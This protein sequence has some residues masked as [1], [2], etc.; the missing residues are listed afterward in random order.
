MAPDRRPDCCRAEAKG[1]RESLWEGIMGSLAHLARIGKA[2]T[3]KRFIALFAFLITLTPDPSQAAACD[4][5][6]RKTIRVTGI[7]VPSGQ[8]YSRPFVFAM[9]L[10]CH[11]TKVPVT[12]Q[13]PTGTL[14]V[15][16]AR[17]EVEV[18]GTLIWNRTLVDGHYEINDPSSVTCVSVA[19]AEPSAPERHEAAAPSTQTAPPAATELPRTQPRAVGSGVWVGRYTDNRG[20]GDVTF[21]L[22]RGESMMSGTWKQRTGGGG[23]VTGTVEPGGRRVLLKMENIAPE[24]PGTFEGSAEMTETTLVATYHGKDCAGDVTGGRLELRPQ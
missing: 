6:V 1:R 21:M 5:W 17:Q 8:A 20:T 10:D 14:P 13:R 12:V 24:C 22:M 2:G 9:L 19:R 16:E 15:C 23:P 7:Y 18:E 11:G 3:V 4:D